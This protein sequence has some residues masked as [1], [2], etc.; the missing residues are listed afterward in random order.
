MPILFVASGAPLTVAQQR[1]ISEAFA[2]FPRRFTDCDIHVTQ[3]PAGEWLYGEHSART[4]MRGDV[5]LK[6]GIWPKI[7]GLVVH[8]LAHAWTRTVMSGEEWRRWAACY[9]DREDECGHDYGR[10]DPEE[11]WAQS[12]VSLLCPGLPN[13]RP[14]SA[15]VL[16]MVGE[17]LR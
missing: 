3:V 8:E 10:G 17:L 7:P 6:A 4:D 16:E 14:A 13:Y 12:V 5:F 2:L 11:G 15:A 1:A 9:A